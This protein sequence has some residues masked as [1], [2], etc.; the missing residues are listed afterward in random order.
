MNIFNPKKN[1]ILRSSI[2]IALLLSGFTAVKS[3]AQ[4][5]GTIAL[6]SGWNLLG[7][8]TT[9]A[10]TAATTFG[11]ATN[12]ISVWK[13]NAATGNWAFYSPSSTYGDGGIAYAK[14]QGYD[15][16]TT[17]SPGEG[18]WVNAASV[19][20]VTPPSGSIYG[21]ANFASTSATA[22][23]SGWN[24]ISIGDGISAPAFNVAVGPK[25]GTTPSNLTSLW[26]WDSANKKWFFYSP[27]SD[28]ANQLSS[29]LTTQGYESFTQSLVNGIGFWANNPTTGV[30]AIKGTLSGLTT[31]TSVV[32]SNQATGSNSTTLQTL[33][34]NGI[35]SWSVNN[36]TTGT[37]A[38]TV[39]TQPD[40]QTCTVSNGS[41]TIA[42]GITN[43]SISC[44]NS[45]SSSTTSTTTG[46]TGS[47]TTGGSTSTTTSTPPSFTV[48]VKGF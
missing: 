6:A 11:S 21:S 18:Y 41:G 15:F 20:S 4:S 25:T 8:A 43:L 39:S 46:T 26:A 5:A 29:Y 33:T 19:F 38:V 10:I 45:N 47:S 27:T 12:V 40:G 30:I 22:L 3:F 9:S 14:T 35:F 31:G 2:Y 44:A 24:L 32:L 23:L 34:N 13:W 17:I 42:A 28:S 37:Y 1:K 16:L 7:N 36:R 48:G